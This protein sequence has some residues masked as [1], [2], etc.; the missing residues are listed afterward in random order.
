MDA[1]ANTE[2]HA[3][4]TSTGRDGARPN[5]KAAGKVKGKIIS[6]NFAVM[7]AGLNG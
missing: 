5:Q 1:E 3:E 7:V 4:C 2:Q 6:T